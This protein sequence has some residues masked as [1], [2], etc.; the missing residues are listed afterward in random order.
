MF[1]ACR[2]ELRPFNISVH[3]IE[4]GFFRTAMTN[5]VRIVSDLKNVWSEMSGEVRKQYGENYLLEGR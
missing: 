2:R 1:V 5:P 4:P 3:I